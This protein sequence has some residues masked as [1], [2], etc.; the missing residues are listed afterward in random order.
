MQGPE[1][2]RILNSS[3]YLLQDNSSFVHIS[4]WV[5]NN[6]R[7]H[8][9][10]LIAADCA[11]APLELHADTT[12]KSELTEALPGICST[13]L[14]PT[15]QTII[16]LLQAQAAI[17]TPAPLVM[18]LTKNVT[19]GDFSA[20]V[21]RPLFLIGLVTRPTSI[22]LSMV[23]NQLDL[24]AS[25]NGIVTFIS[26][27]LENVAPGDVTSAA[28]AGPFSILVVNNVWSVYFNR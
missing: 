12:S 17:T 16:P 4:H 20:A 7:L 21:N 23:V 19:M 2:S 8:G 6:T 3:L 9:V 22:D 10:T 14:A 26:T 18:F 27:V 25:Q 5:T 24:T 28:L 11:S 13:F 15:N 1:G